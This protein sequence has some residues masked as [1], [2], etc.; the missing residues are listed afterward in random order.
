MPK[1]ETFQRIQHPT[2]PLCV[3]TISLIVVTKCATR[4][5]LKEEELFMASGSKGH[6]HHGRESLVAGQWHILSTSGDR[7]RQM[8]VITALLPAEPCLPLL[9]I[10][11]KT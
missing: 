7:E 3:L 2:H 6:S 11:C 10:Q 1:A 5:D 9:F 4:R 8:Q